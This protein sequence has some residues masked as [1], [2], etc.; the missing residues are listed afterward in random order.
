MVMG[1]FLRKEDRVSQSPTL[2]RPAV[3][4][5]TDVV[6]GGGV[7]RRLLFPSLHSIEETIAPASPS[8]HCWSP[9]KI[10]F[11]FFQDMRFIYPKWMW[12]VGS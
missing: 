2:I 8:C 9:K 3:I 5:L 4:V 10:C 7:Q 6:V 12:L 11:M 1:V